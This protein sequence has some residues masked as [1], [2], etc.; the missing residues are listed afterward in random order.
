MNKVRLLREAVHLDQIELVKYF[1][2][3]YYH[4]GYSW[5]KEDCGFYGKLF[6]FHYCGSG[7]LHM[8]FSIGTDNSRMAELLEKYL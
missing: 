2:K 8:S 7:G 3:N 6:Y 4:E 1:L 5:N